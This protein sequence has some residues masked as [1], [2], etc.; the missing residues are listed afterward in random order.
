MNDLNPFSASLFQKLQSSFSDLKGLYKANSELLIAEF[1][2]P[3]EAKIGGMVVQ[4]TQDNR[5]WLRIHPPCSAYSPDNS[6]EL[7][8]IMR[9]VQKDK[10]LWAIGFLG[11][12]WADTTLIRQKSDLEIEPGVQYQLY[13]WSGRLD[14][15]LQAKV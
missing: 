5:I 8:E 9:A 14:E 13:S 7:I 12:E 15:I 6:E 4:T 2:C 3:T 1:P 11:E 10:V